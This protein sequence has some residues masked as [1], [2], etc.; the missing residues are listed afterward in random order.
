MIDDGVAK[1]AHR[2]VLVKT[3][4]QRAPASKQSQQLLSIRDNYS[5]G[6][7]H[8]DNKVTSLWAYQLRTDGRFRAREGRQ[9]WVWDD[10]VRWT[11]YRVRIRGHAE[12]SESKGG[13]EITGCRTILREESILQQR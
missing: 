3:P 13:A 7:I 10:V 9:V 11:G 2:A 12:D 4:F 6:K 5:Q 1:K 8:V